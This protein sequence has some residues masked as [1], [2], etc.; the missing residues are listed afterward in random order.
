MV[1]NH[2]ERFLAQSQAFGFHRSG[3]H[4]KGFACAYFVCQQG[5]S[6]IQHMGDGAFL[7][8]PQGNGRV[9]AAKS[10]MAAIILAGTGRVH[11]F[12]ILAH[13]SL[14][15]LRVSPDPVPKG[16]P[17][18][19]LFLSRQ[20]GLLGI[21]H[22]A[23]FSVCVL[24]GVI[25]TDIPQVQAVLQNLICIGAAGPVGGISRHIVVGYGRFPLDL[26]FSS[27]GGIVDLDTALEIKRGVEGLIHKLLDVLLVDPGG[28]KA[29]LNF[30]RIQVF[31]LGGGKGFHIDCK[32]RV[33]LCR[34]LCL[35]QFAAYIA[36]KVF[37]SSH[38][39]G[40]AVFLQLSRYTEDHALQL[41]GQFF[42][43]FSGKPTHIAHIYAG[44]FRDGHR[45][46]F[47]CHIHSSH[48]LMGLN[49][50]FGEHIR[51]ALQ[52]S[53]LVNNFQRTEQVI[54][55]IVCIGQA[56][57]TVI[58]ET[59]SGRK[60]V[61]EPVQF[62]LFLGNG[63]V[64]NR[65]IHLK[66]D[67]FLHTIT[68]SHKTFHAGFGGGVEVRAHHAAVFPVVHLPVYNGIRIVLHIGVSR[69]GG[70][71]GFAL[72]QLR[73]LCLLISAMNVLHRIMQLVG[74]LQSL[75]RI[76]GVIHTMSGAYRLLS[77]QHHFRVVDKIPVDGKSILRLSGLRPLWCNVQR[78]VT[79]LE[80]DDV[81]YHLGTG[82]LF[83]RV[84]R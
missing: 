66:V 71:N 18:S 40:C 41:S 70:V 34:P 68:Q 19:L 58:D 76:H 32:R 84:I 27:K 35:T 46:C 28:T 73:Q 29:H 59:V 16:F 78:T 67:Q 21:Q 24:Y 44:F 74:K 39:M 2:K 31:G 36:G 52:L 1:W 65:C 80:K 38:I 79:L 22:A 50:P 49:G 17:D 53:V 15:A 56:V 8:F 55:R 5:I 62:R 64:W 54:G 37:I 60:A 10:D 81:R 12:V 20:G 47:A 25:D 7:V 9:H 43:C 48:C 11:F 4:L 42:F 69:N 83:E 23:L 45:Q 57:C 75:D 51:L 14:A 6:A 63:S 3:H 26:P 33:L 82:I 13:Q 72:A 77:A 61:I 30:R